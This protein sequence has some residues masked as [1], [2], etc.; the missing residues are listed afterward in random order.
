MGAWI[1]TLRQKFARLAA[2][3]ASF[4]GAWIETTV[5]PATLKSSIVASFMGAWIE[6]Q[7]VCQCWVEI[8]VASF[9]GAWIET[10][11]N[12]YRSR[13]ICRILYGCVDWNRFRRHA[14]AVAFRRILYGCVDWNGKVVQVKKG[15]TKVASFTGA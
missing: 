12:C 3:V 11:P 5:F 15:V 10:C 8:P 4:M 1:E 7:Q 13:R 6:T 2:F 14:Q 9:M